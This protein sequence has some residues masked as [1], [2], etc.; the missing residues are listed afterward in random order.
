MGKE[1][2]RNFKG[3]GESEGRANL[4]SERTVWQDMRMLAFLCVCRKNLFQTDSQ[5]KIRGLCQE[6][7]CPLSSL[8]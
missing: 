1:V 5:E 2:I 7:L 3:K 6:I 8:I 4:P